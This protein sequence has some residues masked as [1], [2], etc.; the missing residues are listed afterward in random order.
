MLQNKIVEKAK[1]K[2]AEFDPS[3][4]EIFG[5]LEAAIR[6]LEKEHA[7][8]AK[9]A[10]TCEMWRARCM[11][12]ENRLQQYQ[13]INTGV[14][15]AALER[16]NALLREKLKDTDHL[17]ELARAQLDIVYRIFSI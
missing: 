4:A 10:E 9:V 8:R 2:L 6:D 16:E 15:C 17:L 13:G 1:K 12:V 3:Y 5:E 7:A 11:E 14:D